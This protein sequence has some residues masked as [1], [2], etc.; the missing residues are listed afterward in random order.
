MRELRG[1]GSVWSI[2]GVRANRT[3]QFKL[4]QTSKSE[5]RTEFPNLR[6]PRAATCFGK[7]QLSRTAGQHNRTTVLP[8]S[9]KNA[10]LPLEVAISHQA[11]LV[12][13]SGKDG[14]K[15]LVELGDI[16]TSNCGLL[17]LGCER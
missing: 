3:E 10:V 9:S 15:Q 16:T 11:I 17:D 1:K 2:L 4:F 14:A 7:L 13:A 6:P 5:R 8:E 12:V